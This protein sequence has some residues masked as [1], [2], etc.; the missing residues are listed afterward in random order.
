MPESGDTVRFWYYAHPL[1]ARAFDGGAPHIDGA[2]VEAQYIGEWSS[3]IQKL[4][5]A[6]ATDDLPDVGMVKRGLVA[7]LYESRR[8][9][10]LDTILPKQLMDDLRPEAIADCTYDG[11]PVALPADGF[12]SLPYFNKRPVG[13]IRR[14]PGRSSRHL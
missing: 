12:C 3:A 8:I 1:I 10:P 9:R 11:H 14:R 6:F 5:T 13:S 7:K 2:T 4:M